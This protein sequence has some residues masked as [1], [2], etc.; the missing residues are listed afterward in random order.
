MKPAMPSKLLIVVGATAFLIGAETR[1]PAQTFDFSVNLV[2]NGDFENATM[3]G[4]TPNVPNW[5][6]HSNPYE[7][8]V[9][10]DDGSTGQKCIGFLSHIESNQNDGSTWAIW[11]SSAMAVVPGEQLLW[12]F[13]YK[14]V[15]DVQAPEGEIYADSRGFSDM[16]LSSYLG[17][18][19]ALL[20]TDTA[21]AWTTAETVLEVPAGV[22]AMDLHFSQIFTNFTTIPW[23]GGFRLDDVAVYRELNLKADFN[24]SATVNAVDFSIWK[25]G[26][27]TSSGAG[28]PNGD[29]DSDADVDGRDFLIWQQEFGRGA[30]PPP[31]TAIPEPAAGVLMAIASSAILHLIRRQETNDNPRPDNR[32]RASQLD[33]TKQC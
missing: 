16:S 23:R 27:S 11:Q 6:H 13:R 29:A 20:L 4:G 1:A 24:E 17:R 15:N 2:A 7:I 19:G 28:K 14:I 32:R 3:S 31:T 18:P 10:G 22:T 25:G 5:F 26:F 8:V 30:V 12:R 9:T 33:F 21:G